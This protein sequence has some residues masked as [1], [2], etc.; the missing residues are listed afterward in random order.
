MTADL[1]IPPSPLL[2][3][4]T[5]LFYL[6]REFETAY[7]Y[8]PPG[9]SAPREMGRSR[10]LPATPYQRNIGNGDHGLVSNRRP[11]NFTSR[12]WKPAFG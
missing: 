7:R 12:P 3:E 4:D 10:R 6:L 5:D 8:A 9:G 1:Q 11:A 2:S